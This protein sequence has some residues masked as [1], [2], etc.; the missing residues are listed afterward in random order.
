MLRLLGKKLFTSVKPVA[1]KDPMFEKVGLK[2]NTVY[3]NLR[4]KTHSWTFLELPF[5]FISIVLLNFMSSVFPRWSL[6]TLTQK[7]HW[8]AT[9]EPCAL[10]QER[11]QGNFF[12]FLIFFNALKFLSRRS[13]KDKRIVLDKNTEKDVWWGEVNIPIPPDSFK[14]IEEVAVDYLN[15]RPKVNKSKKRFFFLKIQSFF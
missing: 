10:I 4:Y 7:S 5:F 9:P 15:N 2:N 1:L 11:E 6:L 14:L 13:P 8:S 12:L 3:R